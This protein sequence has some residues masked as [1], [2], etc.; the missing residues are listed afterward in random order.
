MKHG[1]IKTLVKKQEADFYLI[2]E[3]V[4]QTIKKERKFLFKREIC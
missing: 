3:N 4:T 1:E 2:W